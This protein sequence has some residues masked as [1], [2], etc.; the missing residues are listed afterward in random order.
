MEINIST[1]VLHRKDDINKPPSLKDYIRLFKF[2]SCT[3]RE[4]N[5]LINLLIECV[6]FSE[7]NSLDMKPYLC[8]KDYF[9]PLWKLYFDP[10]TIESVNC[11][12]QKAAKDAI[13]RKSFS[14]SKPISITWTDHRQDL[15]RDGNVNPRQRVD[16]LV[17]IALQACAT[18]EQLLEL[19]SLIQ[20]NMADAT[21]VYK[22]WLKLYTEI[23]KL[24][25]FDS[26]I[27]D[28]MF[29]HLKDID[30]SQPKLL[31]DFIY[32][33]FDLWIDLSEDIAE[34]VSG[35]I[36]EIVR[37]ILAN[38]TRSSE[39]LALLEQLFDKI[40]MNTP[41]HNPKGHINFYLLLKDIIPSYYKSNI[42]SSLKKMQLQTVLWYADW[43]DSEPS[44]M[45]LH[46]LALTTI[47]QY[48][49]MFTEHNLIQ[50]MIERC[51]QHREGDDRTQEYWLQLIKQSICPTTTLNTYLR[52]LT[53]DNVQQLLLCMKMNDNII[54]DHIQAILILNESILKDTQVQ[55]YLILSDFYL[56]IQNWVLSLETIDN[57]TNTNVIQRLIQMLLEIGYS[58]Y[59]EYNQ[60]IASFFLN[61]DF[62]TKLFTCD[63]GSNSPFAQILIFLSSISPDTSTTTDATFDSRPLAVEL[64]KKLDEHASVDN[65]MEWSPSALSSLRSCISHLT[66]ISKQITKSPEQ[67]QTLVKLLT[68]FTPDIMGIIGR[69][70]DLKVVGIR[71]LS[72]ILDLTQGEREVLAL[73]TQRTSD[74][75]SNQLI[76]PQTSN[77][78][79]QQQQQTFF[80][81]EIENKTELI[82]VKNDD[83]IKADE[84]LTKMKNAD[85]NGADKL[86]R[87]YLPSMINSSNQSS[88]TGVNPNRLV[89]TP[90]AEE[91]VKKVLE[92]LHDPIPILLEGSTGVGKSASIIEAAYQVQRQ[93][94]RFN[95]S[96]RVTIDDLLGKVTLVYDATIHKTIFKFIDGPFTIA[97]SQGYWMLLD[98]LNLAQDT[99]L[100]AIESALDTKQLT[101]RNTSSSTE[102]II[103][104]RM[105]KN[106]RL[107][108]TQN[109][110]SGFFKGKRE[111]LSSSFLSRF[112]PLIF[113]ELPK[114]EWI[115]IVKNK[116]LSYFPYQ[117]EGLSQLMV[118]RFNECV[119]EELKRTDPKFE[120]I[121][122]Y[123][124]ITIRELLK[125][126]RLVIWQK[127]HNQWPDEN[128]QQ[129][130]VLSFSAW[131]VYGARYRKAG[132]QTIKKIL[133]D[134]N[135]CDWPEPA[136]DRV[137]IRID[138]KENQICFDSI[139]CTITINEESM[140]IPNEWNR[141]FKLASLDDIEYDPNVWKRALAVHI[142]IHKQ[143]LTTEFIEQHGIYRIQ[144]VWI[145]EWLIAAAKLKKLTERTKLAELGCTMY[146]CRFRHK[147]AQQMV[148]KC[149]SDIFQTSSFSSEPKQRL[150]RAELPYVLSDRV[151]STLKQVC[152]NMYIKQPILVTGDEACGK[153]DL[154]L[155]LSWFHSKHVHQLNITPE[156]EPSAL[157]G[158]LI[159]NEITDPD[160]P[161]YGEK[162]IWQNGCVAEAYTSGDWVLLDNLAT[163]ESSVLER[164]NPVLEQEPMLI[165]TEKGE[166]N[167]EVLHDEYQL[168]ATM[169][170]PNPQ[171]SA[172]L[173][174]G[175]SELSPALYNRFGVI[176]M[177]NLSLE[178][179]YEQEILQLSK[180]I[181]SDGSD[182]DHQLF[183]KIWQ[184][185]LL[186]YANNKE[187]FPKLTMRNI[188]RLLDS[189]FLLQ[190]KTELNFRS[191]L[192][193]AYHVTIANQI[194]D[195]TIEKKLSTTIQ[196]LLSKDTNMN[197]DQ[198]HFTD[199]WI[200]KNNEYILTNSRTEYANAVLGSIAC[201]I[202]LLLE[203]PAAVGK[204]ALISYLCKHLKGQSE[205]FK[206]ERVNNTD[207]TTI[208]D[209]LGTFLPVNDGFIFQPG[210]LYRA[211]TNGW[212]F[213][214][215][216]FN[217]ADPSVMNMLFPLLEGKNS[218]T[219]PSS[220]KIITAKP[221]FH[222]FATQNDAS[223]ANRH[224]LPISL[225]NRFLEVQFQD[226][227]VDE[228]PN[229]IWQ[230]TEP[231]KQKPK[232]LKQSTTTDLAK[233]YHRVINEPYRITFREL[234]KWLHRH[235][236]FSSNKDLWSIVGSS[237]LCS[238]FAAESETRTKLIKDFQL[239][240]PQHGALSAKDNYPIEIK[241]LHRNL[242]DSCYEENKNIV[243]FKEGELMMDV[244][245]INLD[246]SFLWNS[247]MHL[248]PPESFQRS[249]IRIAFAVQAKE[250]ILLVGPTS[251][252]TLLVE[253]WARISNR[254]HDLIKV[255][256]T[257]DT[258]AGELIGEIHPYSF[259]DLVKRLPL[260]AEHI[261]VRIVTLCRTHDNGDLSEDN[262]MALKSI[263][264]LIKEKLP[265][266]IEEFELLY[267]KNEKRRQQNEE[268]TNNLADL[269]SI[270]FPNIPELNNYE[271]QQDT[272]STN[273]NSNTNTSTLNNYYNEDIDIGYD[274]SYLS[275]D[276]THIYNDTQSYVTED[277]DDGFSFESS[278]TTM[279]EQQFTLLDDGFGDDMVQQKTTVDTVTEDNIITEL[280][281]G[282]D[283]VSYLNPT[284]DSTI[285]PAPDTTSDDQIDDGFTYNPGSM[286]VDDIST[287]TTTPEQNLIDN[288]E[289]P[290][291]LHDCMA[292]LLDTIQRLFRLKNFSIFSSDTTY[293]DYFNKFESIWNKLKDPGFDRTK[294]IFLFQD[295]PVTVATK[296]G[297]ILFLE[298]LDLPSQAVIERLNS[299][300]EPTPT[301]ALTEDITTSNSTGDGNRG[302]LDVQLSSNF[303]VFASVHQDHEYQLLKL[304]PATRSRFTEIKIP[305]YTLEDLKLI[306]ESELKRKLS[307]ISH[308]TID[309]LVKT[310]FSIRETLRNEK[311]WKIDNDIRLL[312]RWID[313]ICNQ[314]Y[315]MP[316]EKRLILGAK[317]YYFDQLPVIEQNLIYEKWYQKPP[318]SISITNPQQYSKIFNKPEKDDAFPLPFDVGSD[319]ISLKYTGV[320]YQMSKDESCTEE[321]VR[322]QF[323]CVPTPT[324]LNQMA[325]IFAA[326]SSKT[327]LLL[328]GPPGIGKTQVV[329]QVCQLLNK[330]CE[331]IN[332]SANTS[333]D[334]LIGCI[335][336]RCNENGRRIFEWQDGKI[337]SALKKRKWILLDELNLAAPEVLEG[338]TPLLYRDTHTY[339][340]PSTGETIDTTNILIFA[341]M[342]P[343][344]IG[345]GRSKLPRSI[346]NLFTTV[347]LDD[348]DNDELGAILQSLFDYDVEQEK[349]ITRDH[350]K[351]L[352][353][354]HTSLK[355]E[356]N[357]GLLGR[358]GG[359]YEMNLRDLS[360][361]RDIFRGC[362]KDQIFHYR[363][364]N[365]DESSEQLQETNIT[366]APTTSTLEE[367]MQ[368]SD[369]RMLSIRKFAEVVYACQFHGHED[370]ERTRSLI[371]KK[372]EINEA[373]SA[374]EQD[375]SIDASVA[376]VVRI[377][378]IYIR[379][380]T[381][382]PSSSSTHLVHTKLT[383]QQLELLAA[384][385]QSKRSILLEGDICSRKSSLVME[386]ANIT[387][388]RLIVIPLNENYETSDLIGSWLPSMYSSNQNNTLQTK[389][390]NL[391]KDIIKML[392][393]TCMPL[394]SDASNQVIFTK[395]K[396]IL[397]YR[398]GTIIND[399]QYDT[400]TYEIQALQETKTMLENI[401]KIPQMSIRSKNLTSHYLTQT[402]FYIKK[403]QML[404]VTKTKHEM[405]F[406]FVE[407]EFVE[408]IR[409]GWWVLLDNVN[410]APSEVLERLNSLT[411]DN[412]ILNLYEN[413]DG[414]ILTQQNGGIHQNFRLFTTA[415]LNRIYTNKLSSAFLNRVIRLWLPS[416]DLDLQ[417]TNVKTSDLYELVCS[418][419]SNIPAGKQLA[420]LILMTHVKVKQN[421]LNG[422]IQY[423]SDFDI[424]YRTIEQCVNTLLYRI[425]DVMNPVSAVDACYWSI[426]RSY[427]SSLK[428]R[429]HYQLFIN[430]LQSTMKE[431]NLISLSLYSTP[432]KV[433][434]NQP[435]WIQDSEKIRTEFMQIEEFLTQIGFTILKLISNDKQKLKSTKDLIYLFLDDIL[436]RMCP[437]KNS[438]LTGMK[439]KLMQDT[440]GNDTYECVQTILNDIDQQKSVTSIIQ[441]TSTTVHSV[442]SL[443]E[444]I[445]STETVYDRLRR[446]LDTF[447]QNT[448]FSDTNARK[449]FLQR[450]LTIV[451]IFTKFY[452][453]KLFS[454]YEQSIIS[455]CKHIIYQLRSILT[456]KTKLLSYN[457]FDDEAF[458]NTKQNFRLHLLTQTSVLWAVDHA[459]KNPIRTT[460]KDFRKLFT[461]LVTTQSDTQPIKHYYILLEWL[462][463]QW[464]FETYLTSSLKDALTKNVCLSLDF[465]HECETKFCCWELSNRLCNIIQIIIENLPSE[466]VYLDIERNYTITKNDL[467]SKKEEYEKCYQEMTEI[468]EQ[469]R[470]RQEKE[471]SAQ[472]SNET[473]T[474][475]ESLPT[476]MKP[477]RPK[478]Q[479]KRMGSHWDPDSGIAE[480]QVRL[481]ELDAAYKTLRDEKYR[482]GEKFA[483][484]ETRQNMELEKT[485]KV[486]TNL[487]KELQELIGLEST[488]YF[489]KQY[490]QSTSGVNEIIRQLFD[491]KQLNS[492]V[493]PD[494]TLDLRAALT[495]QFGK[496]LIEN[497]ELLDNPIILFI[498]GFFF[499]PLFT[500]LSI[501]LFVFSNLNELKHVDLFNS[502]DNEE[503]LLFFC[504][505]SNPLNCC[506]IPITKH[507]NVVDITIFSLQYNLDIQDLDRIFRE[508][509]VESTMKI[510]IQQQ[511]LYCSTNIIE[512]QQDQ[513]SFGCFNS[514]QMKYGQSEINASDT[515]K[516][517]I[518]LYSQI[519]EFAQHNTMERKPMGKF[520]YQ[521]IE[522]LKKND[523]QK[524]YALDI[525]EWSAIKCLR[526]L[527]KPYQNVFNQPNVEIIRQDLEYFI[528]TLDL[529]NVSSRIASLAYLKNLAQNY[530]CSRKIEDHIRYGL[531]QAVDNEKEVEFQLLFEFIDNSKK[532]LKLTTQ[533]VIFG[534]TYFLEQLY[535]TTLTTITLFETIFKQIL[536][537]VDLIDD[538]VVVHAKYNSQ[539]FKNMQTEFDECLQNLNFPQEFWSKFLFLNNYLISIAPLFSEDR[540]N[541]KS[542]MH[543]DG[544]DKDPNE[545]SFPTDDPDE[546]RKQQQKQKIA[547][548]IRDV[549]EIMK[550]ASQLPIRPHH[551]IQRI[552]T[553]LLKMEQFVPERKANEYNLSLLLQ[554]PKQ[555]Q[556]LLDKF[557]MELNHIEL[558]RIDLPL[559]QPIDAINDK[560][561]ELINKNLNAANHENDFKNVQNNINNGIKAIQDEITLTQLINITDSQISSR[562]W[563]NAV[564][565]LQKPEKVDELKA[566]LSVLNDDLAFQLERILA[567]SRSTNVNKTTD[568]P[569]NIDDIVK[570]NILTAY[571]KFRYEQLKTDFS[572]ISNYNSIAQITDKILEWKKTVKINML[573]IYECIE[574]FS[575]N[576]SI[577]QNQLKNFTKNSICLLLPIIPR[578]EDLLCLFVPECTNIIEHVCRKYNE[579]DLSLTTNKSI[580]PIQLTNTNEFASTVHIG[581]H[582]FI[583]EDSNI[584]LFD[585]QK[586]IKLIGPAAIAFVQ[587]ILDLCTDSRIRSSMLITISTG[588][589]DLFPLHIT[590]SL[591]LLILTDWSAA[592]LEEFQKNLLKL[593]GQ[594]LGEHDVVELQNKQSG[595]D[596]RCSE[597]EDQLEKARTKVRE[598]NFYFNTAKIEHK[599]LAE[600]EFGKCSSE[601]ERLTNELS[602]QQSEL[603]TN[604]KELT[605]T[606]ENCAKQQQIEQD[607]WMH[608]LL[609]YFRQINKHIKTCVQLTSQMAMMGNNSIDES[610][611]TSTYRSQ[612]QYSTKLL[613]ISFD[614][615]KKLLS[616]TFKELTIN[617][618]NYFFIFFEPLPFC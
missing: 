386:L 367:K 164:L 123:A 166:V 122:P 24:P 324:L 321:H 74:D 286:F 147:K 174:G 347:Q 323:F 278:M 263:Q 9:G 350:L 407:S 98:E 245:R 383:I 3:G 375:Q 33:I 333:L 488:K 494:G 380:G 176:H 4:I 612:S 140:N 530:G 216:E 370:Y 173:S 42:I 329:T 586:H 14:C 244:K 88:T 545:G 319:Y 420:Q 67:H 368:T 309:S 6:N 537:N 521:H 363:F 327:P 416:M 503:L 12:D 22:A 338:L 578:P 528:K 167:E 253:T 421:L 269:Q 111:K 234:I 28:V 137:K 422:K 227:P 311:E 185:I 305:K 134:R 139:R 376:N 449:L 423:P 402:D 369:A 205:N 243:S 341:T 519:K 585:K 396:E 532:I 160:D 317:F 534:S 409:E 444:K 54:F 181:L 116:L 478:P 451:E 432:Q 44:T 428:D 149:F 293:Q 76:I 220:G 495:S 265:K 94:V 431:L 202:P 187:H 549:K 93:L 325:R 600:V 584:P 240:W 429:E 395:F 306:V 580:D 436:S 322:K 391:F 303:Q 157:I 609:T 470:E 579:F 78:S 260:M 512:N 560:D 224:Q 217:L 529:P 426:I 193:T 387:R 165:L 154:L 467:L 161:K 314:H 596:A 489:I 588:V 189:T 281:D 210:A 177:E 135:K 340:V 472:A 11:T 544:S 547:A 542:K 274:D 364:F 302:Q 237:L 15:Y 550:K 290:E 50:Y 71:L 552:R 581:L 442:L 564:S 99:V 152:F 86:L 239:I 477:K 522:Q 447:F 526:D 192:W 133:S 410:S 616:Q 599:R 219:V 25:F 504:P 339:T 83:F 118:S 487:Q 296:Q 605:T 593:S 473:E 81:S 10:L 392:F 89:P 17:H 524:I 48:V 417:I 490:Q 212:W 170:P 38:N 282:F 556:D 336:P 531:G 551:I 397:Q 598:A 414:Q 469:I 345:G 156:T 107:F 275:T 589:S 307:S 411:E 412:P 230:R 618:V 113:K 223:Y 208:Q 41:S 59:S 247:E 561:T 359:P 597:L 312:F 399:E 127:Q 95:M 262:A 389:I 343:T 276:Y 257:P 435:L 355:Q 229:I 393:L 607:K 351:T 53:N 613:N 150:C 82:Q 398:T 138:Q 372:F 195:K 158:Q 163:A 318:S 356:V 184:A 62:I 441:D 125:W 483:T 518:S 554:E 55:K 313:F 75:M 615:G 264:E 277:L 463:L 117:A 425:E 604:K 557:K 480:Q 555:L 146:Q 252:K 69:S 382:E 194:K 360:K 577:T 79:Q 471:R 415:N 63:F 513:F 562:T 459:E 130:P 610:I 151:L 424:T 87:T 228:L 168:L 371:Q 465:I 144:R 60:N 500:S 516:E 211:M 559:D 199:I 437:T 543:G 342:N 115:E 124:E 97:F 182:V 479:L 120:E 486:I 535:T 540:Q 271:L 32:D 279:T 110:N 103:T 186:V 232:C 482:L 511:Q 304:S 315:S 385:C 505:D 448:C 238:K 100:Q 366:T 418:N 484:I 13:G 582:Q 507:R 572:L 178:K 37:K 175:S 246:L 288:T 8:E 43:I 335:I 595:L 348:Y 454:Q 533:H 587:R 548:A 188:V 573:N 121:G 506:M 231:D 27:N 106:F 403:L 401:M 61:N 51:V 344:T 191:G 45:P 501:K 502:S 349:T 285:L 570:G 353:E 430:D 439:Q 96:S 267:T 298:D 19:L 30:A 266:A 461:H 468:K 492:I 446:L 558:S 132:R 256:L 565:L 606:M 440:D 563:A 235:A 58:K 49:S 70:G 287:F 427:C 574:M 404:Q 180:A 23:K 352:F 198:P 594:K 141:T 136:L 361:F 169:T 203:G 520:I 476:T 209:Y 283:V 592:C 35:H 464:T 104:H 334:Q 523:V 514:L 52:H 515:Y 5:A 213:L 601:E 226:F 114:Q 7:P 145:W 553:T 525:T 128:L 591:S 508:I 218:I 31:M 541:K 568:A 268:F 297:S 16:P 171:Q 569:I 196:Q 222:F 583:Y 284:T 64:F 337:L 251:C 497:D 510:Q 155:T 248:T 294:P 458:L 450:L 567:T 485:S 143:L 455:L 39:D 179:G 475:S 384:A 346:S 438:E 72:E 233:F 250:P 326:T 394:W 200:E 254:Q 316:L 460:R 85:V 614:I 148:E 112:R 91:N 46:K 433:L 300:L 258:E 408:A 457:I 358:T 142:A 126:I 272:E 215:D 491:L 310:M 21:Y 405:G 419:L 172:N 102:P 452:S 261:R 73:N 388:N 379:T 308:Q 328:E 378:S 330:Q 242:Q 413:S 270:M 57:P 400:I 443:S 603:N 2:H 159:P 611:E 221:G 456:F 18:K 509:L 36:V 602:K 289:F 84:F 373:L 539:F 291:S 566:T 498:V 538:Y 617:D 499:M 68:S 576:L 280:D 241:Q 206:L 249:L 80:S 527:L 153:S 362:I 466:A 183:L 129:L 40:C 34:S 66:S 575:K 201:G 56:I 377:G 332:L 101:I 259:M 434:T 197:L 462:G 445:K 406:V 207:T 255:H 162:L 354:L 571:S 26:K 190:Q 331:R 496:T 77:K 608:H 119:K 292:E 20:L 295:G 225:R 390:D 47:L 474:P 1:S 481:I 590:L 273:I 105:H 131:C 301:F 214:A 357:Q 236:L 90:T 517:L 204:T 29:N 453:S 374:R 65:D 546:Y 92:A 493:R 109:P 536:R 320:R 365:T 108:A 299:M 381:E